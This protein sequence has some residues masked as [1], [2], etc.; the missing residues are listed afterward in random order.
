MPPGGVRAFRE[1]VAGQSQQDVNQARFAMAAGLASEWASDF[2]DDEVAFEPKA[3]PPPVQAPVPMA[4]LMDW[5]EDDLA[6]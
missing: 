3:V 4:D 5:G 6:G 2:Q 1:R